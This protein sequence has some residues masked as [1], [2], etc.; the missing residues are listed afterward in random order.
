MWALGYYNILWTTKPNRDTEDVCIDCIF[1]LLLP[2]S[3]DI[4]PRQTES[5]PDKIVETVKTWIVPQPG[6]ISL[7]HDSKSSL[8]LHH[9][10]NRLTD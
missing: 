5:T 7:E 3:N 6:F 8:S 1:L 4:I 9:D 2:S 10:C